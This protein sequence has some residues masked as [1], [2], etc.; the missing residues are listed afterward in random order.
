MFC[1]GAV[2]GYSSG[3]I[4]QEDKFPIKPNS[5]C[6]IRYR[7][8]I[9]DSKGTNS[10]G[11]E[12]LRGQIPRS[13]GSVGDK[14]PIALPLDRRHSS[15]S[16]EFVPLGDFFPIPVSAAGT[17][18][19]ALQ[20]LPPALARTQASEAGAWRQLQPLDW[21]TSVSRPHFHCTYT[22]IHAKYSK[23]MNKKTQFGTFRH[24]K[25]CQNFLDAPASL[26]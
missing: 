23:S 16:G 24:E 9:R 18:S 1:R 26:I 13:C 6:A 11:K 25:I 2:K 5:L 17:N 8:R 10:P 22:I 15:A 21:Q 3:I 4:C 7:D 12:V 14:F 20:Y 19:P